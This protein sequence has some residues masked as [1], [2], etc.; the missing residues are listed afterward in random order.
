VIW[1]GRRGWLPDEAATRALGESLGRTAQAGDA[2]A[3]VGPLAAGKTTLTQGIAKGLDVPADRRVTSP[4]FALAN[5]LPG[6]LLLLHVDVYR[7]GSADEAE[8][9]GFRERVGHEGLAVIEWADRFPSLLPGHAVWVV[10][11]HAN[12]GRRAALFEPDGPEDGWLSELSLPGEPWETVRAERPWDRSCW[13][14]R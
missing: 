2:L 14:P 3:L 12:D 9:L 4:T 11:E 6:R 10:L 13:Q 1:V 7:L 5:E 8:D